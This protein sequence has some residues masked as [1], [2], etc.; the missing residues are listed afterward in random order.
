MNVTK[1]KLAIKAKSFSAPIVSYFPPSKP[2]SIFPKKLV[3]NHVPIITDRNFLGASFDTKDKPIGDKHNSDNVITKYPPTNHNG[4]TASEEERCAAQHIIKY[5][6][7]IKNN[8]MANFSTE[9]GSFDLFLKTSH[10]NDINGARV[11]I[12]NGFKD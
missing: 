5:A 2:A 8:D 1:D 6:I 10:N 4:E 9:V 7:V 3:K 11:I 12:N